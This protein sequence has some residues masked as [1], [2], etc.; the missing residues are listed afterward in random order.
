VTHNDRD[1]EKDLPPGGEAMQRRRAF[2]EKRALPLEEASEEE[3][4]SENEDEDEE[5]PERRGRWRRTPLDRRKS[6]TPIPI[7][8]AHSS[9]SWPAHSW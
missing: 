8:P 5:P 4:T 7:T 2:L 6:L 1:R 9:F 3:P